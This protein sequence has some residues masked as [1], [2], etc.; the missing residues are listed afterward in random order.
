MTVQKPLP[1]E[2]EPGAKPK[3]KLK[4]L[5]EVD[6]VPDLPASVTTYLNK[7]IQDEII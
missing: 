6:E 2:K 3:K 5:G 4:I 1:W 7:L